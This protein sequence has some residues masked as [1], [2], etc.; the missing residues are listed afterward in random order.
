MD[1][2]PMRLNKFLAVSGYA[3]RRSADKLIE[4]KRVFVNGK[5]GVLGQKV[6][7]TDRVEIKDLDTKKF[8]Y[9]LYYKPRGIVTHSPADYETDIETQI[10]K[11]HSVSGVFPVGRLDKESEGLILLTNDGRVTDKM[12]N[13]EIGHDRTYE[14]T[15]DKRVTQTFLNGLSRGVQIEDYR[16]KPATAEKSKKDEFTFT[17]TLTEGKK[18]QIRR[19]CARFGYQV[20]AL[21]RTHMHTLEL[22]KLKPG[23]LY[24][25]KAKE[26]YALTQSLGLPF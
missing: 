21:K 3:T 15:V 20:R 5:V 24:E 14:V 19:M 7:E 23:A 18:H 1:Q 26:A 25:L 10:K 2:F 16:T 22:K 12:L 9:I 11:D 6:E 17:I 4:E 13:P 8:R